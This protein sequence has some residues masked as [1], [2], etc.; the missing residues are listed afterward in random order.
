MPTPARRFV[1]DARIDKLRALRAGFTLIELLTVIGIIGI[2]AAISFGL[3]G[4]AKEKAA[5]SKA[6]TELAVLAQALEAYKARYGDYPQTGGATSAGP[7]TP[8]ERTS[9]T[10]LNANHAEAELFNALAGKSGPTLG[11]MDQR[12]F[13]NIGK[14][15]LENPAALP[16]PNNTIKVANAFLDPWGRRYLYYY[17]DRGNPSVWRLP[18]YVLFSVGPDQNATYTAPTNTSDNSDAAANPDNSENIYAK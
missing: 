16:T 8:Q 11:A 17:K 5:R 13:I 7:L 1:R 15:T 10:T 6:Q 12:A 2:L 18:S 9:A 14:F 3:M 4:G